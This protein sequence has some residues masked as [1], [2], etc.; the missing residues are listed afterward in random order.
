MSGPLSSWT[1]LQ[2]RNILS[3]LADFLVNLESSRGAQS[4]LS[5][6]LRGHVDRIDQLM[7]GT[8]TQT[9]HPGNGHQLGQ[10]LL[11]SFP[12]LQSLNARTVSSKA[13]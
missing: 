1:Y 8:A 4:G 5:K 3:V 2:V 7:I 6:K 12:D 9:Q 10:N 13:G 11:P